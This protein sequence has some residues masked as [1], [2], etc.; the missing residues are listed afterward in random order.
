MQNQK[1]TPIRFILC[2][3]ALLA[4]GAAAFAQV[5]NP[6][7]LQIR[8]PKTQEP[9]DASFRLAPFSPDAPAEGFAQNVQKASWL[10]LDLAQIAPLFEQKPRFLSFDIPQPDGQTVRLQLERTDVVAAGFE[11]RTADGAVVNVPLLHYRGSVLGKPHEAERPSLAAVTFSE[12]RVM[13]VVSDADGKSWVLGQYGD[14]QNPA[15]IGQYVFYKEDDLTKTN[16]F[17]CGNADAGEAKPPQADTET[18]QRTSPHKEVQ[19]YVEVDNTLFNLV[20]GTA[21]NAI[22]YT[23]G[24]FN[25]ASWIYDR[26]QVTIRI[27]SLTIWSTPDPY[28]NSTNDL[29]LD[30]LASFS[31]AMSGGFPG[32]V[33]HLLDG[34]LTG[35]GRG[36]VGILCSNDFPRTAVSSDLAATFQFFPTYS[37]E[38]MVV[39]HEL[40]HNLGSQHTQWCGWPGGAI[41]G[42]VPPEGNCSPGPMPSNGGTVMSYCHLNT[43][44]V[45][46]QKGFGPL[47]GNA[48]RNHVNGAA[49]VQSVNFD[50]ALAQPIFCG[51]SVSAN[52]NGAASNVSTY[53]C[54]GWNESGPERAYRLV[55]TEPGVITAT[56]SGMAVD[57]DVFILDD[58]SEKSC[59]AS[60]NV[61]ASTGTLPPGVY[62]I[63]VDGFLGAAGAFTLSVDCNGYC[64]SFGST[65]F[66]YIESVS[67]NGLEQFSGNNRGYQSA[68]AISPSMFKYSIRRGVSQDFVLTPAFNNGP[69]NVYWYIWLDLNADE[70][71]NDA[72]EQLYAS[73]IAFADPTFGSFQ[74][75]LFTGVTGLTQMRVKMSF[76]PSNTPCGEYTFGET[77]D[78]WVMLDDYCPA[79][80][81][82][83]NGGWHIQNVQIGTINNTSGANLAGYGNYM[84]HSTF[85]LKGTDVPYSLA[86]GDANWPFGWD[87]YIDLNHDFDFDDDGEHALEVPSGTGTRTGTFN[88]PHGTGLNGWARMRVKMNYPAN[89]AP[90]Q[91][92]L[93]EIEDYLVYADDYCQTFGFPNA[94]YIQ[95]VELGGTSNVSG[96]NLFGYGDYTY[97]SE[98]TEIGGN[99]QSL[100]LTPGGNVVPTFWKVYADVNRDFDFDDDGEFLFEAAAPPSATVQNSFAIPLNATPGPVRL[101]VVMREDDVDTSCPL[102]FAGETEDYTL[103]LVTACTAPTNVFA[104]LAT[105]KSVVLA[106]AKQSGANRYRFRY[107][108]QGA[109][110]WTTAGLSTAN[111][112]TVSN[113]LPGTTYEYEAQVRCGGNVLS[114]WSPTQTFSVPAT[115]DPCQP[116]EPQG[117]VFIS[118]TAVTLYHNYSRSSKYQVR[119]GVAG[120]DTWTETTQSTA[121]KR[122]LTTLSPNTTYEWQVRTRCGTVWGDWS[123]SRFFT[124]WPTYSFG[125]AGSDDRTT[126]NEFLNE[127]LTE[128]AALRAFPNPFAGNLTVEFEAETAGEALLEM[129]DLAGRQV[130]QKTIA[131]GEGTN[132]VALETG[133]LP[134]GIWFLRLRCGAET[135]VLRLIK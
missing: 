66:E 30:L 24:V 82:G 60:G 89:T 84:N 94:T 113:L 90:C 7:N 47:P 92:V 54:V 56:L 61:S 37:W 102:V 52:T 27:S 43:P 108:V 14:P 88:I 34:N 4:G 114:D 130:V 23:L 21:T 18:A 112:K 49:C 134:T 120:T 64:H 79:N 42:C 62:Y 35:C 123:W 5:A 16:P 20:G 131:A 95:S 36:W 118:P 6:Q 119:Y 74:I 133:D 107:R 51:Q 126:D 98:N 50:C 8:T 135:Q 78:Y 76:N 31:T 10:R 96:Q 63:V 45:N 65:D 87:V 11:A 80:A 81:G 127:I 104:S 19:V 59:L 26:E 122:A 58:C 33:A 111:T 83:N 3:L 70:D 67:F 93:G 99:Y 121:T 17:S 25:V 77:E 46:L 73:P 75:P 44:G 105:A 125:P 28:P 72:G 117:E 53:S 100:T 85:I 129:S 116:S 13:A 39:T 29:C 69:R 55:T 97:L 41:D 9:A 12:N 86:A 68:G 71:F 32:D 40:G 1:F 110:N 103:N 22:F 101:R 109:G 38:T 15:A 48:V 115:S 91:S 128:N 132:T 57:L 124:T 106:Q 2:C